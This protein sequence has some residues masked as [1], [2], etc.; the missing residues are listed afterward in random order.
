MA[1]KKASLLL[2]RQKGL[3]ANRYC[4]IALSKQPYHIDH[5]TPRAKGG[6]AAEENL[7]LLCANCNVLKNNRTQRQFRLWFPMWRDQF[8]KGRYADGTDRRRFAE[9]K[10]W[11]LLNNTPEVPTG[12]DAL[13]QLLGAPHA[14]RLYYFEDRRYGSVIVWRRSG[15][16]TLRRRKRQYLWVGEGAGFP[17]YTW[18]WL[19]HIFD[20]ELSAR[21]VRVEHRDG[22]PEWLPRALLNEFRRKHREMERRKLVKNL[23]SPAV[24]VNDA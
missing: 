12:L 8:L 10:W 19:L 1:R 14:R 17:D 16:V 6:E 13:S 11:E 22:V 2:A 5:R 23:R 15:P 24:A 3:C 4:R 9:S 7:Q 20:R 21:L 18:R